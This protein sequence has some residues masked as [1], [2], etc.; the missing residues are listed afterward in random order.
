MNQFDIFNFPFCHLHT[1]RGFLCLFSNSFCLL[2]F[3]K[4]K[5][6]YR[7]CF[8]VR[9]N[10]ILSSSKVTKHLHTS[11]SRR[12]NAKLL[13]MEKAKRLFSMGMV[14]ESL[15]F[16]T[17][18]QDLLQ[19]KLLEYV[20]SGQSTEILSRRQSLILCTGNTMRIVLL[21][22]KSSSLVKNIINNTT[23]NLLNFS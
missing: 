13:S 16:F 2:Q 9:I 1:S 20:V 23:Y 5:K 7:K 14:L 17:V 4:G 11:L 18:H 12:V 3:F 10:Q 6:S 15:H 21:L 19:L 8:T 22:R